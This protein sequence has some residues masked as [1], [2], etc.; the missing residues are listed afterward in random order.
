MALQLDVN[1]RDISVP[2]AYVI[3][4]LPQIMHSKAVMTFGAW[5]KATPDSELF[6]AVSHQCAYDIN[7]ANPFEQA[8]EYLKT[9]P[10]FAGAIDV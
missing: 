1:F 6:D 9:L 8:Y 4:A 7:G 10:E 5:Y 3:A 2:A